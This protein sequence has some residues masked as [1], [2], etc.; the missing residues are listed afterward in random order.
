ML[1]SRLFASAK[2]KLVL[3]ENRAT[4]NA[5]SV[6]TQPILSVGCNLRSVNRLWDSLTDWITHRSQLLEHQQACF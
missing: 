5:L 1:T 3:A 4:A 6:L 2:G